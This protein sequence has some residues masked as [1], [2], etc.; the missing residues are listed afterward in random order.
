MAADKLFKSE[1]RKREKMDFAAAGFYPGIP[2][3]IKPA[4]LRLNPGV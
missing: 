3:W 4:F 1:S 2:K